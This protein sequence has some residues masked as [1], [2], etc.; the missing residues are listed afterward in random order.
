M[1]I[2]RFILFTTLV[3]ALGL[4]GCSPARQ[5]TADKTTNELDPTLYGALYQQY[6]AEYRAL[7]YQ[8]YNVADHRLQQALKRASARPLAIVLDIDETVLD[9][10]P[11]QAEAIKGGFG[12]PEGWAEWMEAAS[13]EPL[14]GVVDFLQRA[15]D[16]GVEVFYVSNRKD[17]F[18]SATIQNLAAKNLPNAD[19]DHVLLRETSNEKESR[20]Q[21]IRDKYEVI[22][23]IGDNLGDFDGMFEDVNA[24]QRMEATRQNK[25][26]FGSRWI[27]LPNA[28]YG[29]WVDVLP[30]YDQKLPPQER[31][32]RLKENLKGFRK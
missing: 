27:I 28:V 20:R 25:S 7:C 15:K 23:L 8:A 9:N 10:I 5:T 4:S 2:C 18:K 26:M 19:A 11:Y 16:A 24:E 3:L 17:I 31:N 14:A 30:G 32:Q 12:Y 29:N 6:A 22:M 21:R 1:K 13:A